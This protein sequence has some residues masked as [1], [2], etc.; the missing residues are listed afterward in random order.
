MSSNSE[1]V[2]MS[3]LEIMNTRKCSMF[4]AAIE[5]CS[6][7]EID[8]EDFLLLIDSNIK[9]RLKMDA[10]SERM[11]RRKVAKPGNTLF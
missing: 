1:H 6:Q 11:V 9:E 8:V 7:N 10:I 2:L 3:I 5:F 4:D